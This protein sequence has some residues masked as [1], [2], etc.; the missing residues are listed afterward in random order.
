[1][2]DDILELADRLWRGEVPSSEYHPVSHLGGLAEICDGVAFVPA[3]ANAYIC[4][5]EVE[6]SILAWTTHQDAKFASVVR[7]ANTVGVQFH[8]EKSSGIGRA[9]LNA[10]IE[11]L[12]TCS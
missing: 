3:F 1:M 7:G 12:I 4:E 10:V 9:F 2:P 11:D 5:P 8:P 6:S